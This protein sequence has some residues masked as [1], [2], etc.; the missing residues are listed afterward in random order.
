MHHDNNPRKFKWNEAGI[1][2]IEW[3]CESYLS[4]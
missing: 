3:V 4:L 1:I 2:Y